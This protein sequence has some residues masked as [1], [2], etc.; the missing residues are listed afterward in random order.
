MNRHLPWLLAATLS[1]AMHGAF[2]TEATDGTPPVKDRAA[3]AEKMK[4]QFDKRFA[5]AD[6]NRDGKLSREEAQAKMPRLA[7]HFDEIDTGK[8]GFVT[9][10]QV[11]A[12]MLEAAGE[13]RKK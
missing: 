11:Q 3:R 12:R 8:T 6:A 10:E 2:A 13:R 9:K 1:V 5:E 7:Q 4:A